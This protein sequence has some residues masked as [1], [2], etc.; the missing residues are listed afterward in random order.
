MFP[1]IILIKVYDNGHLSVKIPF[2]YR[3]LAYSISSSKSKN[4]NKTFHHNT[5]NTL[6]RVV[7]KCYFSELLYSKSNNKRQT[8]GQRVYWSFQAYVKFFPQI[9]SF[10]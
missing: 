2:Q 10:F 1:S 4:L 6:T 7:A 9:C 3:F 5:E 8:N